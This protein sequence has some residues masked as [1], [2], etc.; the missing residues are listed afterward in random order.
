M[1]YD[2]NMLQQMILLFA[3][4]FVISLAIYMAIRKGVRGTKAGRIYVGGEDMRPCDVDI[5]PLDFY[6]SIERTLRVKR[7]ADL[8][9]GDLSRYLM[10]MIIGMAIFMII[11]VWGMA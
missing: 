10:W 7:V 6:A 5:S 9:N 3:L 4:F 1:I 2:A 11:L 8:H